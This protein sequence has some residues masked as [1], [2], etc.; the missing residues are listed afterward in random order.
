M[1]TTEDLKAAT[2]L[3][4]ER[5]KLT[6]E[7]VAERVK[8]DEKMAGKTNRVAELDSEIARLLGSPKTAQRF[9]TPRARKT[10]S[11]T[12]GRQTVNRD[13][14]VALIASKGQPVGASD[15]RDDIG[16]APATLSNILGE[17]VSDGRLVKTGVKRG[18]KYQ[19]A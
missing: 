13:E 11:A 12:N 19:V 18:T 4:E 10:P 3:S 8:F 6:A 9:S 2:T 5:D 1:F 14:I 16:V 7:I 17:L 15:L